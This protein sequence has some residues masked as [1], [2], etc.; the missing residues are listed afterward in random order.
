MLLLR[1]VVQK[2]HFDVYVSEEET[3]ETLF[4]VTFVETTSPEIFSD[5]LAAVATSVESDLESIVS[6]TFNFRMSATVTIPSEDDNAGDNSEVIGKDDT[7]SKNKDILNKIK[8]KYESLDS[9]KSH[10]STR[11]TTTST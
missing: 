5:E 3:S 1:G 8:N 7:D 6:K 9:N 2:P 11:S 4:E 10:V